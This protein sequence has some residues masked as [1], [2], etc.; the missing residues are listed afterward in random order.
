MNVND[1]YDLIHKYVNLCN[2]EQAAYMDER[3]ASMNQEELAFFVENIVDSGAI[4]LSLRPVSD[5]MTIDKLDKIYKEFPWIKQNEIEVA[6]RG[7]DGSIRYV[8]ARRAIVVGKQYIHRLKQ[9]AEEKF[10]ATSLSA[11]N[12]RNENTK[13]RVKKDFRE[14]YSNTPIRFGKLLPAY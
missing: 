1:A 9:Y 3:K 4:H 2:P 5:S 10:S 12:I 13:S 11:T 6:L 7:S 8:P 14:L